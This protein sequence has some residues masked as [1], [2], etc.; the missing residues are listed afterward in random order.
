MDPCLSSYDLCS[1]RKQFADF[2]DTAHVDF[3]LWNFMFIPRLSL[4]MYISWDGEL[5]NQGW[6]EFSWVQFI[7]GLQAQPGQRCSVAWM[8]ISQSRQNSFLH[9]SQAYMFWPSTSDWHEK[10]F[11]ESVTRESL[12]V[13]VAELP[14]N[15]ESYALSSLGLS[16]LRQL[17]RLARRYEWVSP[18][19]GVRRP[20]TWRLLWEDVFP[21]SCPAETGGDSCELD[22]EPKRA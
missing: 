2:L 5:F 21:G 8:K 14:F 10:Q 1:A 3:T 17:R 11:L 7:C 22:V 13:R 18:Q 12:L 9:F 16:A 15:Q 20:P 4:R 6:V 19:S